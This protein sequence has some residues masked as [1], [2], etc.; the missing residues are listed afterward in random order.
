MKFTSNK[1]TL[2]HALS[3]V[4]GVVENRVTV[5]ILKNVLIQTVQ[6]KIKIRATDLDISVELEI[7]AEI[8]E[9][10][11]ITLPAASLLEICRKAGE[12]DV[13]VTSAG[14]RATITSGRSRFSLGT[15]AADDFPAAMCINEDVAPINVNSKDLC[16]Y[17]H[18]VS[19]CMSH[20][21]TRYYLNGVFIHSDNG[22]IKF[23]ATDGHKLGVVK[24]DLHGEISSIILPRK[25]CNLISKSFDLDAPVTIKT[26]G[27]LFEIS[28]DKFVITSKV[29][30]GTYPDYERIMPKKY[31]GSVT[32]NVQSFISSVDRV[33]VACDDKTNAV[34]LDVGSGTIKV[35]AKTFENDASDD[36]DVNYT[37]EDFAV[38]INREYLI[39]VLKTVADGGVTMSW[40]DAT[41]AIHFKA[42]DDEN[43]EWIVMPQ[44]L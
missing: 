44:R 38:G 18:K 5:P 39:P 11:E 3:K 32:A 23:V 6:D 37:G 8:H 28:M 4:I 29:I 9:Q 20:E 22:V 30:D 13:T 19:F 25:T 15:M 35:T 17:I 7:D 2:G 16:S 36:F 12:S 31:A 40:N 27:S 1:Q 41:G 10:G 33:A 14:E 43:N 26:N 24:S 34:R 21:E 42:E